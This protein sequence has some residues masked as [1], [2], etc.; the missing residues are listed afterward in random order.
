MGVGFEQGVQQVTLALFTTLAPAG[1]VAF[2]G[3]ALLLL[4]GRLSKSEWTRLS[5]FLVFPLAVAVV[6]FIGSA[7]HLGKP[8]NA[9]YVLS[10]FGR[11]PLSN[12]VV[13]SL[14]FFALSGFAWYASF[15]QRRRLLLLVRPCMLLA[16]FAGAWQI[17]EIANAYTI[18][19]ISTWNMPSVQ[20]NL[21]FAAFMG[22]ALLCVCTLVL[23]GQGRRRRLL[24]GLLVMACVSVVCATASQS[25]QCFSLGGMRNTSVFASNLAPWYPVAIVVSALLAACA[26]A[27]DARSLR[28]HGSISSARACI[29]CLLMFGGVFM[30]RFAFY[31]LHM[32]VGF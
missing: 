19:T 18:R 1:T 3:L 28:L 22:G 17:W 25:I 29:A 9:L 5:H 32:T 21:M 27:I 23:A 30:V 7:T 16:C 10:G 8:S 20:A 13:A 4:L 6:G 26:I 24:S 15:S 11:S 12:E 14:T 2:C 31:C